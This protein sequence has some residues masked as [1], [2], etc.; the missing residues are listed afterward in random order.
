MSVRDSTNGAIV[1][2]RKESSVVREEEEEEGEEE[3]HPA[4]MGEDHHD[5]IVDH[6]DCIG[7]YSLF[8]SHSRSFRPGPRVDTAPL[9]P[10]FLLTH[11]LFLFVWDKTRSDC[12]AR[13]APPKRLLLDPSTGVHV[14]PC[15]P[16]NP[17]FAYRTLGD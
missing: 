5:A 10:R 12:L 2:G 7:A 11:P 1:G 17:A 8:P 13:L 4:E 6:L 14:L 16:P 3:E 15:R 9:S